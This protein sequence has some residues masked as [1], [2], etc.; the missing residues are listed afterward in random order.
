MG[1]KV[2]RPRKVV[3]F[4]DTTEITARDI[5]LVRTM[6]EPKPKNVAK[7]R[8]EQRKVSDLDGLELVIPGKNCVGG[9]DM[10]VTY[11][12]QGKPIP[13]SEIEKIPLESEEIVRVFTAMK[14]RLSKGVNKS[15]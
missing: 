8:K 1:K 10:T 7:A 4:S 5:E 12:I 6:M 2:G 15:Q 9:V 13:A 14:D 11:S 3:G